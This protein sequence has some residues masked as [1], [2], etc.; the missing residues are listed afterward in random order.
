VNV[1]PVEGMILHSYHL[2]HRFLCRVVLARRNS[3]GDEGVDETYHR[4]VDILD[5]EVRPWEVVHHNHKVKG[6]GMIL[7]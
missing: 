4:D 7:V 5:E 2:D 1:K 6:Q 3:V